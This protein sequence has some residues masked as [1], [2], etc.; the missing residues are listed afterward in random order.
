MSRYLDPKADITFKRVFGDPNHKERCISLLNALLPLAEGR[1]VVDIEY[2][3]PEILPIIL[4]MRNSIAD[5]RCRD[6]LGRQFLV[7][8]QMEWTVDFTSRILFNAS[9]AFVSQFDIG[10]QFRDAKP[11]YSLNFI[12]GIYLHEPEFADTYYHHYAIFDKENRANKIEGIEFVLVELPKFKAGTNDKNPF[13]DLWLRF[14]TEIEEKTD[15]VPK[16]LAADKTIQS[17]IVCLERGGYSK[18]EMFA[19]D[20]YW[21]QVRYA[22]ALTEGKFLD[23]RAEGK[24]EGLAEGKAEGLAEGK[25]EANRENARKMLEAGI[26]VETIKQITGISFDSQP[27]T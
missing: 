12:N 15:A 26:P 11:V 10:S 25:A 20:Y 22:W 18:E 24:A 4:P 5:V 23:G 13:R 21:D 27:G 14:L 2:Q 9:K 7:E 19:Y 6:N 1:E 3:S 16:D 8:M 17:A